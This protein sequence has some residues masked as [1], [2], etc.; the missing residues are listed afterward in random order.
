MQLEVIR[1]RLEETLPL[2]PRGACNKT[3]SV[4]EEVM[5]FPRIFGEVIASDRYGHSLN[6]DSERGLFVD[7]TYGQF[8][9]ELGR[10]IDPI[11]IFKLGDNE[12]IP[13]WNNTILMGMYDKTFSNPETRVLIEKVKSAVKAR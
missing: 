10:K 12:F 11:T 2:F 1:E 9:E 8:S 6:Y 13:N 3:S 7:L 4:V 5:R